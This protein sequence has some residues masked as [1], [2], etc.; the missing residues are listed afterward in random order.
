LL[1]HTLARL[2]SQL[3]GNQLV[4]H[5]LTERDHAWLRALIDE[6]ERGVGSKRSELFTRLKEPLATPA[7]KA[8]QRWAVEVLQRLTEGRAKAAIPPRDARWATFATAA[9]A[10]APRS[11]VL[12]SAALLLGTDAESLDAAL[13][14]DLRSEST[15]GALPAELSPEKIAE[16]RRE[17]ALQR[18]IGATR[19][20]IMRMIGAEGILLAL[21]GIVLGTVI[22]I[23]TLVPF[24]SAAAQQLT[25]YGPL[26]IYLAIIGSAAGLTLLSTVIPALFVLRTS[27]VAAASAEISPAGPPPMTTRS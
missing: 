20:Q 27:P 16:R 12:K 6:Y 7:P 18:L 11:E 8:K 3:G 23:A 25:P 21:A 9:S 4:L 26:W 1:P 14:A 24:S 19:G 13:F 5:Y 10:A 2:S 17:F 22:A 15:T